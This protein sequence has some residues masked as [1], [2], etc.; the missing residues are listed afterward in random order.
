M[1]IL[2]KKWSYYRQNLE[3]V[4]ESDV[5]VITHSRYKK[6]CEDDELRRWFT[7]GRTLK[8]N[9]FLPKKSLE[10]IDF[11]QAYTDNTNKG[12]LLFY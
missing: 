3:A 5:L 11:F 2:P 7:E 8:F 6:L 4:R 12:L 10:T 9:P 1:D